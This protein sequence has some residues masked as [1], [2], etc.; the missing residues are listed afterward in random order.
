MEIIPIQKQL[1][2]DQSKNWNKVD[3]KDF[4]EKVRSLRFLAIKMNGQSEYVFYNNSKQDKIYDYKCIRYALAHQ[5]DPGMQC[6]LTL[7]HLTDYPMEISQLQVS[8]QTI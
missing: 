1:T 4:L 5:F 8:I 2:T 6:V 7:V 3:K